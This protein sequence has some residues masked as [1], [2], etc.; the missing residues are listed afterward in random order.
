MSAGIYNTPEHTIVDHFTYVLAGDGCMMEGITSEASSL[1]GHLK[2]GKLIAYYDD[3]GISID[4]ST[5]ITFTE[6]VGRRYEAYGWHVQHA[7]GYDVQAIRVATEKARATSDRPSLII[8]TTV[9][10]K[11]SPNKAGTAGV[12]G[13]AL[14]EEEVKLTR[15]ALGLGA[16]DAFYIHPDARSFFADRSR[17]LAALY[18][19]WKETFSAW[20]RANP[21]LSE[22]WDR[23]RQPGSAQAGG[24]TMPDFAVGEKIATRKASGK[25]LNALADGM[26]SVIGGSA[27]LAGSNI[28][29]MPRHGVFNVE[30]PAGRTINFGVREHAMGA[31]SNGLALYGGFRPFCATFLVFS[32]YLR[33]AI[34]LAALMRIPVTYVFTHD[35]IFVGEDGPTHQPVEHNAALRAIPNLDVLRPADAQETT[36]AWLMAAERDT[37]PTAI[38]LTRQN[39]TVFEKAD[40]DWKRNARRGGYIALD[41]EGRPDVIVVASGSEVNLA[42]EVAERTA[43]SI[44]VVSMISLDRFR[45]QDE[46]FRTTL[47]PPGIRTVTA[48]VGVSFGWD[49]IASRPGDVFALDRFGTSG[50]ASAAADDLGFNADA[51]LQLVENQ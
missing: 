23:T 20:R 32:D 4:G 19:Q 10:G 7:D 45:K 30:T 47:I 2:L 24:V 8:L 46:T 42:M 13:A 5:D 44:R 36:E 12:H 15:E 28:T 9:I 29:A 48:E 21:E 25:A 11:G 16:D 51:L 40:P 34:R 41:C 14:G 1:A 3:N 35:S 50:P 38:L 22:R 37:G 43:L 17:D 26:P 6:D 33:P 18:G 49:G 31:I 27:D 39:L